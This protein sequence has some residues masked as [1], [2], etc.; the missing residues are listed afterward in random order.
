MSATDTT[1]AVPAEEVKAVETPAPAPEAAPA[2]APAA[3]RLFYF[4]QPPSSIC[5]F[6]F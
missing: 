6:P 5:L 4:S 1:A 3:V 2:E